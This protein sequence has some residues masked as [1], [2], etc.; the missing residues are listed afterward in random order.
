[1]RP[2]DVSKSYSTFSIQVVKEQDL[3]LTKVLISSFIEILLI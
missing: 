3:K 2:P 1:M